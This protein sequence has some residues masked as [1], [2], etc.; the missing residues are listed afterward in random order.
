MSYF[1]AVEH[2]INRLEIY[3]PWKYLD[4]EV[5]MVCTVVDDLPEV[6]NVL[7]SLAV[8]CVPCGMACLGEHRYSGGPSLSM[9]T[10]TSAVL[11]KSMV[12]WC[13]RAAV[14]VYRLLGGTIERCGRAVQLLSV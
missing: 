2:T 11:Q 7:G 10:I 13:Q 12:S 14:S 6:L 1:T 8:C 9:K 4:H 5:G 3:L